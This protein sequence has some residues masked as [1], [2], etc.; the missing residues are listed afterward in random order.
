MRTLGCNSAP[1]LGN[2]IEQNME[3]IKN[4][5]FNC[6]SFD[7]YDGLDMEKIMSKANELG[8]E[9]ES[10]KASFDD[11]NCM[12][13]EGKEGDFFTEKLRRCIIDAA[14]YKIPYVIMQTTVTCI[15]P[16][17]SH[18]ALL[19][20]GKLVKEAEKQGIK[21][22]F[23][24]AELFRHLGILLYTF[25]SDN[26]GFCYDVGHEVCYT[27]GLNFLSQFADRL[28]CVNFHDNDGFPS[29][30]IVTSESDH[31][32]IPFD[33]SIDFGK[34][35]TDIKN[36]GYKGTIM[37]EVYDNCYKDITPEQFYSKA[38]SAAVKIS[39]IVDSNQK[40]IKQ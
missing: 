38:Y 18:I 14:K 23:M 26:V 21:I 24:N 11:I 1:V 22:A 27:P 15:A 3:N 4:V 32:K 19:R 31:H 16:K 34:V 25:K 39:D 17:T 29:T 10:L 12:W 35:C 40:E 30:K 7:W 13:E 28:L 8:L 2:S 5:G 9:V 33:G 37:L 6:T 20:F 36:C